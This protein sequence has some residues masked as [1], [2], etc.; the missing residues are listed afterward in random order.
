MSGDIIQ[1]LRDKLAENYE[2]YTKQLQRLRPDELI[3]LAPQIVARK[4]VC[5]SL[6]EH[7]SV[8]DAARLLRFEN[9]LE[10]ASDLWEDEMNYSYQDELKHLLWRISD[11]EADYH[12]NYPPAAQAQLQS[13][14]AESLRK[15]DGQEGLILQGCGGDL[16][17]W[18]DGINET[19]SEAGDRKSVV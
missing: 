11:K 17:E 6:P 19:L 13:I 15:M 7:C 1:S 10:L 4:F 9:P 18:V 16:Q 5:E 3:V 12:R 2:A 8:D 14:E